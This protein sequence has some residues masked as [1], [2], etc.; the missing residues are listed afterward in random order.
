VTIAALYRFAGRGIDG[1]HH[2]VPLADTSPGARTRCNAGECDTGSPSPQKRRGG[3]S[4][5]ARWYR[6]SAEQGDATAQN[7]LPLMYRE[8]DGLGRGGPPHLRTNR[9]S[10][11]LLWYL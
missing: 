3:Q 6:Q 10:G 8:R 5:A 2:R 1:D 4:E 9:I 11:E 7:D